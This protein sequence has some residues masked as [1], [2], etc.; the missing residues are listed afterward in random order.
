MGFLLLVRA[1]HALSISLFRCALVYQRVP[2]LTLKSI[3]NNAEI[4]VIWDQWQT[5]LEPMRKKLNA[6][7]RSYAGA[8]R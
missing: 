4:D 5:K 1:R 2:H 8:R 6:V 3:A 7:S